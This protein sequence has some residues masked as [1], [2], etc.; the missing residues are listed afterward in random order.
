MTVI[1][2]RRTVAVGVALLVACGGPRG[3]AGRDETTASTEREASSQG[4]APSEA[5]EEAEV[6]EDHD[7]VVP[8]GEL[9]VRVELEHPVMRAGA[10]PTVAIEARLDAI[11]YVVNHGTAARELTVPIPAS[12][13][14][15][16]R[17][18]DGAGAR[19]EL[20][21][22]PPPVPRPGGPPMTTVQ[23]PPGGEAR[24]A[25]LY[26]VSGFRREG[27]RPD[28]WTGTPPAGTYSI[29]VSGFRLGG[30]PLAAPPVELVGR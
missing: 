5:R 7:G 8:A 27:A 25:D 19:W 22:L 15:E 21:F 28:E 23:L 11:V 2:T 30:E 12:H 9:S 24:L 14:L 18:T 4:D 3:E 29:V 6:A 20:T 13:G 10:D 26:G 17:V 16:W 1:V